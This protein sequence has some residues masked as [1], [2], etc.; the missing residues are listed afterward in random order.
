MVDTLL[1]FQSILGAQ[2][3]GPVTDEIINTPSL[4]SNVDCFVII[5]PSVFIPR[6]DNVLVPRRG[7]GFGISDPLFAQLT[8]EVDTKLSYE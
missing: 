4:Y 5:A 2:V 1:T 8:V 7:D 3:L 6:T